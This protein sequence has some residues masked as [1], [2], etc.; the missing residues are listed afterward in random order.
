MI[1]TV[2]YSDFVRAYPPD[3]ITDITSLRS[4]QGIWFTCPF[5][6]ARVQV[7]R[8][9]TDLKFDFTNAQG[10]LNYFRSIHNMNGGNGR[11]SHRK[12]AKEVRVVSRG[13]KGGHH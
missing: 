8:E 6:N 2:N 5:S 3:K 7:S 1:E 10:D 11:D 4:R 13:K 9:G 12:S